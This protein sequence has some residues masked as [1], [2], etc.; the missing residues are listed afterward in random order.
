M[1]NYQWLINV[2]MESMKKSIIII[3]AAFMMTAVGCWGGGAHQQ[4][5]AADSEQTQSV[6]TV[7]GSCDMC[8]ERIEKTAKSV[9]GVASA[10]WNK[11]TKELQLDYDA[12][13]TSPE[14]VSKALAQAG[15]DAGSEKAPD[16]VYDALPG[17][18]Q[19]RG[20]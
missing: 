8:K 6:L 15:H 1:V 2:I 9:E 16:D 5:K 4:Q 18:C 17:C 7:Q 10:S 12:A 3:A 19:Y 11:E 14:A 13:K 20:N